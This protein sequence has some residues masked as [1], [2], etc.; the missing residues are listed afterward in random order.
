MCVCACMS[1]HTRLTTRCL[2]AALAEALIRVPA[3]QLVGCIVVHW[4]TG[5]VLQVAQAWKQE[6]GSQAWCPMGN[7]FSEGGRCKDV[8]LDG[9]VTLDFLWPVG[10]N[11]LHFAVFW[12]PLICTDTRAQKIICIFICWLFYFPNRGTSLP[13]IHII[14]Y[15]PPPTSTTP[16]YLHL[17]YFFICNQ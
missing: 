16:P 9:S 15:S 14:E 7:R 8:A 12:K 17:F 6:G 5:S 4:H 3:N 2:L 10:E 13:L 1:A 11:K